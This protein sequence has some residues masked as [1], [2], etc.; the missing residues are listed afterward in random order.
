MVHKNFFVFRPIHRYFKTVSA[1]D[2]N[3]LSW[4]SKGL[5][6]QSIKPPTTCNKIINPLLDYVGCKIRVKFSGDCLKQEGLTFNQGKI[7]NIYIVYEIERNVNICSYR[8][9]ENC[10]FGAVKLTKQIDVDQRKYS[11][12]GIGFDRK[13]SYS[14]GNEIGRNVIISGVDMSLSTKIHN[15]KED[16]FILSKGPTQGLEHALSTEKLYSINFTKEDTK[17]CLSLHYNVA[18]S[19][20]F[21]NG[22]EIIKFKAKDSEITPYELCLRNLSKDWSVDNMKKT[23]LKG[24][25][26][27]FSV[28][29]DYILAYDTL[30]IHKYLTEKNKIVV[31]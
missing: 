12:Y 16:I 22:T 24:Y 13:G 2:S 23:G 30:G 11:G 9:L 25:V 8:M 19:Y 3:I 10:L 27:D 1:N 14:I 5:S 17:F 20:L 15:R 18:N 4:K 6:D 29:Y 7:V 21:V 31:V 26:Y 28:D